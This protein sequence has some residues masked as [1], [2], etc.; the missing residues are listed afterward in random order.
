M[1]FATKDWSTDKRDAWLYGIICGWDDKE[2]MEQMQDL[3]GWSDESCERLNKLH[4]NFDKMYWANKK[5][6]AVS[7]K[8]E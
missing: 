6:F 8:A 1:A 3:H 4:E 5:L 2:S 7:E